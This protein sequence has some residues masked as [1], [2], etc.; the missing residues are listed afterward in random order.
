MATKKNALVE[1]IKE[2]FR[3]VVLAAV[4]AGL[5]AGISYAGGIED[6]VLQ[7]SL[8]MALTGIGRA[9]DKFIHD[10]PKIKSAGIIPF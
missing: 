4:S 9:I 1:G 7:A 2:F 3:V 8:V 5:T 10:N 6:Q